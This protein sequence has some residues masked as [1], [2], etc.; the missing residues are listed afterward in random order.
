MSFFSLVSRLLRGNIISDEPFFTPPR[1]RLLQTTYNATPAHDVFDWFSNRDCFDRP[2]FRANM[3]YISI[4]HCTTRW[5]F[6][7]CPPLSFSRAPTAWNLKTTHFVWGVMLSIK[8]ITNQP[9]PVALLPNPSSGWRRRQWF[10]D[11][12]RDRGKKSR[13]GPNTKSLYLIM[14]QRP[15]RFFFF[16][17]THQKLGNQNRF[18]IS[19]AL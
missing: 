11:G 16:F 14:Y 8:F 1:L 2:R 17:Y 10:S 9:K 15:T 12:R 4:A 19:I 7:L 13:G 5:C 18:K 6:S 3:L